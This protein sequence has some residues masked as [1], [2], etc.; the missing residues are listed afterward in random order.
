MQILADE[1]THEISRP[2]RVQRDLEYRRVDGQGVL[3]DLYRPDDDQIYPLVLMV[4]G[5][6]WSSGD[7]W[8]LADHAR[9]MAQAGTFDQLSLGSQVS[10]AG[11]NR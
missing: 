6:A 1:V 10:D 7:K 3:A 4:H 5:G 9:E 8:N 11:T 2:L